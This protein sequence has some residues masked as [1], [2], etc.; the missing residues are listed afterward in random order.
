[1]TERIDPPTNGN[2]IA[3]LV[4]FL[5]FH[6]ETFRIKAGGLDAWSLATTLGPSTMT[7][8]GMIKH[9][10][11]VEDFW[12]GHTF[13][14]Q[15]PMEPFAS[16]PWEVD[17]DWDWTSAASEP[18]ED[19]W[20]LFDRSLEASDRIITEVLM[21]DGLDAEAPASDPDTG[22]PVTLRWIL[23][24]LIEEYARHNGHADLIRQSIDGSTGE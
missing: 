14:G 13:R 24:H 3:I 4:G 2:E 20:A 5:D 11:F 7:L 12:L 1:M 10:A 19:L 23:V 16:A 21:T 8:G 9:L 17:R 22:Q 18:P 15:P 6:R